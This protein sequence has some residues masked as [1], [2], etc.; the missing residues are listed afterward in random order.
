MGINFKLLLSKFLFPIILFIVSLLF[1]SL[2][3]NPSKPQSSMFIIAGV[4]LLAMAVIMTLLSAGKLKSKI[5]GMLAF[6]LLP[7]AAYLAYGNYATINSDIT[8]AKM[9]DSR[10]MEVRKRLEK[11]REAQIAYKSVKGKYC[12]NFDEL[13]TFLKNDSIAM[14]MKIGDD[15]DT[16]AMMSGDK[17][18]WSRDTVF[19]PILGNAFLPANYPVDSLRYIP[20]GNGAQFTLAAGF[21]GSPDEPY[22]P[23]VFESSA[24]FK[25]FLKDLCEKYSK[26]VPD[27]TIRVGS[28]VEPTTNGNWK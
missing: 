19:K 26:P 24:E 22:R 7:L 14:V 23:S 20:Y 18:K 9:S 8:F 15:E 25:T 1:V 10:Y 11:I 21:L 2:G 28:L 16:L 12:N 4:S 5:A 6:I 27:S 17:T 13:I 3:L